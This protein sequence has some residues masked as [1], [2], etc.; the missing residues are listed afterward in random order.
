[1]IIFVLL[2]CVDE[3]G[4]WRKWI[5]SVRRPKAVWDGLG[6]DKDMSIPMR[7]IMFLLMFWTNGLRMKEGDGFG[8]G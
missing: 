8:E 6:G 7:L 2:L 4:P 3:F 1:M 5:E